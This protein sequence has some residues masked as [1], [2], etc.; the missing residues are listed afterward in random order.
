[1]TATTP[2][3]DRIVQEIRNLRSSLPKPLM[4][5][6]MSRG[7]SSCEPGARSRAESTRAR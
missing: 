5:I 3:A 7:L 6:A 1:M 2:L 4:P